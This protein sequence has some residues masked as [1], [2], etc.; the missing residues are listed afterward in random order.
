[1]LKIKFFRKNGWNV[2]FFVSY[3]MFL[4]NL[5][6]VCLL[7]AGFIVVEAFKTKDVVHIMES[8]HIHSH[9]FVFLPLLAQTGLSALLVQWMHHQL[10]YAEWILSLQ[11]NTLKS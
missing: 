11:R 3:S 9:P 10:K 4:F 6:V 5:Y 7:V 8:T 1:M 2:I